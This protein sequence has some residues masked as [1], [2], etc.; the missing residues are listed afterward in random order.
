MQY[1][2]VKSLETYH[3]GYKDRKL[4]WCKAYFS[5]INSDPEFMLLD[6][7]D[8]WRFM[9]F[10]MLELQMRKFVPIYDK[11]LSM[12]GFDLKKRKI[13]STLHVLAPFIDLSSGPEIK[14]PALVSI[15]TAELP[16]NAEFMVIWKSYPKPV[17][18]KEALRHYNST[19]KT[20][21]DVLDIKVALEN[22]KQSAEVDKGFIK[23]GSTWF[24]QWRDWFA[25]K[26]EKEGIEKWRTPALQKK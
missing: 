16:V 17:G 23:N 3:P 9:A 2:H 4:I 19:V 6:E 13:L 20:P 5:M 26:A 11:F 25:I 22:Y 14:N 8:K 15:P 10:I 21:Q 7:V 18:M 24:N 12:K 1:L